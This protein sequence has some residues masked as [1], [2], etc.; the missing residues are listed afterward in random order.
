M[1]LPV[2]VLDDNTFEELFEEA[3]ALIPRHAPEWTDHNLSDPGITLID[4]FAWLA[5]MQIYS[6]DRVTERHILK[7]LRLLNTAPR[8]AQSASVDLTFAD[9]VPRREPIPIPDGT[10]VSGFDRLTG[11]ERIFEIEANR[12]KLRRHSITNLATAGVPTDVLNALQPLVDQTFSGKNTLI[13]RLEEALGEEQTRRYEEKVLDEARIALYVTH[14]NV[15]RVLSRASSQW[16][17]QSDT[18]GR[19]GVYYHAF[20]KSPSPDDAL[21]IGFNA[22]FDFPAVEILLTVNLYEVDLP[23][24]PAERDDERVNRVAS[25]TIAWEYWDGSVWKTLEVEDDTLGFLRDGQISFVG[26]GDIAGPDDLLPSDLPQLN[27]PLRWIRARILEADYEISPRIDT[28]VTNTIRATHG[29][30]VK[31]EFPERIDDV[32][33]PL[34][35]DHSSGL[36]FQMFHLK[37]APVLAHSLVLK[38]KEEDD[39]WYRW[40]KAPDFDNSGPEDR[41]YM[42]DLSEG[43]ITFGDAINGRIPPK[44]KRR[45]KVVRYRVGGGEVGNVQA[46]TI[47]QI[48]SSGIAGITVENRHPAT[49]GS[50]AESVSAG[51]PQD[52][53][54]RDLKERYRTITSNDFKTLA[55]ATPG[56]R[57]SRAKVLPLYHPQL[58]GVS[59]PGAVTVVVVPHVLENGENILPMPSDGLLQTVQRYLEQKRIVTTNLHVMGPTFVEVT[60]NAAIRTEP[61]RRGAEVRT[62]VDKKL[63]QYLHPSRGGDEGDG[64]PF[65]RAVYRS[66][67]YRQIESV[68]GVCCVDHLELSALGCPDKEGVRESL[69]PNEEGNIPIPQIALVYSGSHCIEIPA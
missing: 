43:I 16:F 62:E 46:K 40:E 8:P 22:D 56:L 23:E 24:P 67:L 25:A 10:Q 42:L 38:V 27:A 34:D 30:T 17:D 12:F 51:E 6:L 13:T 26:P 54:R 52:R 57:L 64:W 66:D 2:P 53:A 44:G 31:N 49:G 41:H 33:L 69:P 45:V 48:R 35:S 21:Y 55:L 39:Q 59:V 32:P 37:K 29:E 68:D 4:L 65:G 20:G 14:L 28:I 63:R 58:D 3:R 61:R 36:P 5:E 47:T 1:S 60:V 9:E 11:V 50:G 19:D 7:F 18:N 15:T